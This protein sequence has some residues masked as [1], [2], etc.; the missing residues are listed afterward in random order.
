MRKTENKAT[1]YFFELLQ[2]GAG[3]RETLSGIPAKDEWK[4][5]F[6]MAREQALVGV[7]TDSVCRLPEEM[8]PPRKPLARLCSQVM[9]IED[10]NRRLFE[11]CATLT[12]ALGN[13]GFDACILKGQGLALLYPNPL[14][15]QSGDI[16]VWVKPCGALQNDETADIEA[17]VDSIYNYAR[18]MGFEGGACYHHLSLPLRVVE[19]GEGSVS[20]HPCAD[21]ADEVELHYRPSLMFS[22]LHNKRMQRWYEEQWPR[23]AANRVEVGPSLLPSG[24]TALSR[25]FHC[26]TPQ[27]N[28]VYALVH[29]YR[30]LFDEGIGLR[31]LLD[32]YYI[33]MALNSAEGDK[34]QTI[35]TLK[36]LG[37]YR[38][39]Q[40]VMYVLNVVFGLPTA[41]MPVAMNVR[42][43]RFLLKEVLQA[44]NFGQYD[45]RHDAPT[46]D[47]PIVNFM[48]R[49]ARGL[50]MLTYFPNEVL[51]QPYFRIW[52]RLYRLR[53]GWIQSLTKD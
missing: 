16:D 45:K 21:S 46:F 43:G 48:R 26:P 11:K 53:H 27:F 41:E 24:T 30:H 12:T 14:L 49:Q 40:A 3:R 4:T 7:F 42:C 13:D 39:A 47:R 31:Q 10:T 8:R 18:A 15:R 22:P 38:F 19:N 35:K 52:H 32:Y 36:S 17:I 51:W 25:A 6:T 28:A 20:L 29:I 2:M 50:R 5:M 23:M 34:A 33:T 44:G 1:R 37:L 9:A